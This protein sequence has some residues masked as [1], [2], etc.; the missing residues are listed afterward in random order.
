[1]PQSGAGGSTPPAIPT[2]GGAPPPV[3]GPDPG[4]GDAGDIGDAG[5]PGPADAAEDAQLQM[6]DGG[7]GTDVGQSDC[8]P[9]DLAKADPGS[10]G[11]GVA[12]TDSDDDLTADCDDDCPDDP[13]KTDPGICG[14]GRPDSEPNGVSCTALRDALVHRYRF[15]S[16]GNDVLDSV[17]GADGVV[18]NAALDAS[19][20]L[21]LAGGTSNEYV[22]LPNGL[23]SSLTDATIEVW[24]SW[25]GGSAW[26]RVFDFGDNNDATEGDQ[27][28]GTSYLFLTPNSSSSGLRLAFSL[29]GSAAE[30]RI[31]ASPAL[32]STGVHHLAAVIDDTADEMRLYVDGVEAGSIAFTAAL[33]GVA[34]VNNW[35]GRSQYISDPELGG[36][37]HELR[38]Y[39]AALSDDQVALSF[40]DGPDPS[41]LPP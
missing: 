24:I 14:C 6:P 4:L 34:D 10:C 33:S 29:S 12:D 9:D 27:G 40:T 37:Y 26:Q 11:C 35:L 17:G 21:D 39:A 30:T 28:T 23:L 31:E 19:G 16:E 25:A 20:K 32:P 36:S 15:E 22:D 7:C 1:M 18:V 13:Q 38:I 5:G 41:Y 3:N 2:D 8:C